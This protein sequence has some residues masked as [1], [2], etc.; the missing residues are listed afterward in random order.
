L[1][2]LY[3]QYPSVTL[4]RLGSNAPFAD[5]GG[6]I[7]F[8]TGG[9]GVTF[10]TGRVNIILVPAGRDD[11]RFSSFGLSFFFSMISEESMHTSQRQ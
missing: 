11:V 10:S 1:D 2:L 6:V 3:A 4:H 8:S 7:T 9:G 5:A